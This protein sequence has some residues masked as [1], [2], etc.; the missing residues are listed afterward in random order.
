MECILQST[1]EVLIPESDSTTTLTGARKGDNTRF[2]QIEEEEVAQVI[3][4]KLRL[5]TVDGRAVWG[6]HDPSVADQDI[7][8]LGT[9]KNIGCCLSYARQRTQIQLYQ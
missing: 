7:Q 3:S 9:A 6:G 5:E 1:F 2:E 4:P 8:N